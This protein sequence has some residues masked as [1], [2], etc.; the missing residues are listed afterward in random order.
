LRPDLREEIFRRYEG[1]PILTAAAW[2]HTVNAVFNPAV[3][4]FEGDTLLLA[5]V[6]TRT[7]ISHLGVARSPDGLTGWIIDHDREMLPDPRSHAEEFGIED[8]RITR[9]GDEYLIVYTGYSRDG[10]LVC[11]AATRDFRSYQRRGVLM[12]API[13]RGQQQSQ[14]SPRQLSMPSLVARAAIASAATGSAH[15]HP[16]SAFNSSPTSSATER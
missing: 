7:G 2:P 8:P 9:V 4:E 1:N 12:P 14:L 15:H 13:T 11:L 10:P 5:R 16:A 3:V 6:E